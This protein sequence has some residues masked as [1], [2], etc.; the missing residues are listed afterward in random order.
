MDPAALTPSPW[1][2]APCALVLAAAVL[3]RRTVEPLL[4]GS[5]LGFLLTDGA[6]A[7]S[8]WVGQFVDVLADP[9]VA[10]I[11]LVCGLFGSLVRVLTVSGAADGLG[12]VAARFVRGRRGVLGGA[13]LLGVAVFVDDYLN[14]LAVGATMRRLADRF[15]VSRAAL[16]YVVDSTAAP[17]CVLVPVST[18][19][20]YMA[21]LL[22]ENG[23]AADG[24]GL[25]VYASAVPMVLYAWAAGGLAFLVAVG[26]FPVVGPLR[27]CKAAA[28]PEAD[29]QGDAPQPN[30]S[31]ARAATFALPMLTLVGVTLALDPSDA[32]RV[33][34]AVA[35][36]ILLAV[37]LARWSSERSWSELGD[38]TLDGFAAMTPA[39]AIIVSSFVLKEANDRLGLTEFVVHA[40]A[41]WMTPTLLPA[42]V[43][44]AVSV[45]TFSTG[46]FWGTLAVTLPIV[47]PLAEEVGVP[48]PLAVGALV[49]AGA[50]GSHA[51]FYGDATVLSSA[52]CGVDNTTHAVTQAP[53]ALIAAA[54]ATA[55]YLVLGAT[56]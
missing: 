49:S 25:S 18:W 11:V 26:W 2:L 31:G 10:W 36:A 45:V 56:L 40:F 37:A 28:R 41:P 9:D 8:A 1:C 46:S 6:G 20:L 44:V 29:A 39:L 53:Y 19:G 54:V 48:T 3:T 14:A 16:A 32:N 55:G 12:V 15:G 4:A 17:V 35:V 47:A 27:R 50:F 30:R 24:A 43:F 38:A 23:L 51:C 21:G 52:A 42:A 33:L 34:K 7:P 5:A 13:W 22:E